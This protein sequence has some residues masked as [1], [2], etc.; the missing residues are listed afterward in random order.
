MQISKLVLTTESRKLV[1]RLAVC[2][3]ARTHP[4]LVVVSAVTT[5]SVGRDSHRDRKCTKV[6][7]LVVSLGR[8]QSY[9]PSTD[10]YLS[11]DT[12]G[13]PCQSLRIESKRKVHVTC[14][15]AVLTMITMTVRNVL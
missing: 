6:E 13:G 1:D 12:G 8:R 10:G 3:V 5:R 11:E 4:A 15:I 9:A 14:V 2:R 7:M